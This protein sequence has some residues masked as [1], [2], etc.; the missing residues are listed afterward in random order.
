MN[1]NYFSKPKFTNKTK[2]GLSR[3]KWAAIGLTGLVAIGLALWGLDKGGLIN[4]PFLKDKAVINDD[5]SGINYG[6][7]TEEEIEE[8]EDFK[9]SLPGQ[10][11]PPPTPPPAGQ[12]KTVTPIISS[13]GQV[14]D[15]KAVEVSGYIN[16]LLENGGTCTAA[17]ALNGQTVTAS[18]SATANAQ[19]TSCGFISIDRSQLSPGTWTVT[20]SYSS[21]TAEGSSQ[22][23]ALEVQ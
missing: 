20:L 18:R 9:D 4:L 15:T 21:A 3:K 2:N 14:P 7:P 13:W 5:A 11:T 6:P 19:N 12:K 8:T 1:K 22:S 23:V 16:N 10:T 17:L